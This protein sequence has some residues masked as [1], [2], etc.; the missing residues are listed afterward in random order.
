MLH[1]A[2]IFVFESPPSETELLYSGVKAGVV[3]R[4]CGWSLKPRGS[5]KIKFNIVR[6]RRKSETC[7]SR[8]PLRGARGSAVRFPIA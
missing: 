3:F 2:H 7:L 5:P 6:V 8:R 1:E 4:C